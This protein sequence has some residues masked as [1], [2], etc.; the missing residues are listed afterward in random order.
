MPNKKYRLTLFID[1]TRVKEFKI[2]AIKSGLFLSQYF[3]K[4]SD[5]AE[6]CDH[7]KKKLN[8]KK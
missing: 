7:C 1:K 6:K 3:V 5:L 2:R 4:T 8:N